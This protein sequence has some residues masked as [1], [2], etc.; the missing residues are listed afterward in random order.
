M[1]KYLRNFIIPVAL[2]TTVTGLQEGEMPL[3]A[4]SI[5]TFPAG[6]VN[7]CFAVTL[8]DKHSRRY[9]QLTVL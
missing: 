5:L 3:I 7:P 9:K 8:K 1:I 2:S 4:T 6:A